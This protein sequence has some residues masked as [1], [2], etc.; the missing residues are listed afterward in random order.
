MVT[1]AESGCE[2][3]REGSCELVPAV[4]PAAVVDPTGCGDAWRGA[5]LH[6]LEQGWDLARCARTGNYMGALKVAHRGPQNYQVDPA[7]VAG[8]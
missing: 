7:V 8:Y 5:L 2:V 3:W 4:A 6:G 1:L